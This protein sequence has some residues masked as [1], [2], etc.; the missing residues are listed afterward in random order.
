MILKTSRVIK[1]S[2]KCRFD[3]F[4]LDWTKLNRLQGFPV[5]P[6][7]DALLT[8]LF[9]RGFLTG[10]SAQTIGDFNYKENFFFYV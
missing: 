8:N 10:K 2:R 4:G 1:K 7:A 6:L 3:Q 5:L 9:L